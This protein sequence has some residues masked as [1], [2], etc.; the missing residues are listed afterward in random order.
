MALSVPRGS[1]ALMVSRAAVQGLGGREVVF[2]P[3]SSCGV[4]PSAGFLTT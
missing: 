2:V 4:P 1:R 3:R